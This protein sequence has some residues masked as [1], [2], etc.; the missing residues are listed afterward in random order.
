MKNDH[1]LINSQQLLDR[2][3]SIMQTDQGYFLTQ[4]FLTIKHLN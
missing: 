2:F 1:S 3:E 4:Y